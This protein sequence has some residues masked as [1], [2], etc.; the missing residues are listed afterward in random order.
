MA[1]RPLVPLGGGGREGS[2]SGPSPSLSDPSRPFPR[3][4]RPCSAAP[5]PRSPPRGI[6]L[7]GAQPVCPPPAGPAQPRAAPRVP[8]AGASPVPVFG[9]VTSLR[10]CPLSL[11]PLL[12]GVTSLWHV[13][14]PA[15]CCLGVSRA[16]CRRARGC[17][18]AGVLPSGVS[19]PRGSGSGCRSLR[20]Q[21]EPGVPTAGGAKLCCFLHPNGIPAAS[22]AG[23]WEEIEG[24]PLVVRQRFCPF[25][26]VCFFPTTAPSAYSLVSICQGLLRCLC[27]HA[28]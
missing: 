14:C 1:R 10:G 9:G 15:F 5:G 19:L 27:V 23:L 22:R 26:V 4:S 13:P 24:F 21:R 11:L 18:G 28:P 16:S 2:G 25:V 6:P 8:G 12:G 20:A 3:V 7:R 17:P